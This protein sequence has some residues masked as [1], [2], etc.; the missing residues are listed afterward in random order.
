MT[1]IIANSRIDALREK[2]ASV[3]DEMTRQTTAPELPAPP[4]ALALSRR[5]LVD[6]RYKVLVV[7]EAK[8]GKST[9]VHA[10]I[11]RDLLPTDV[12]IATSQV[13]LVSKAAREGYRVR[14]EDGSA[15]EIRAEDL[16]KY[17]S[18][19]LADA[20]ETP[21]L[22]QIVRWI[23]ADVPA[24]FLPEGI[25]ILDTPGLGSLYAAHD[26]ITQRFIPQADAVIYT[27]DSTQPLGDYDLDALAAILEVTPH[28]FFIQTR[29]DQ[30]NR[31]AWQELQR[32]N[33]QI[34]R[35]RFSG[36][37]ADPRV[38]PISSVNLMKAAQTGDEDYEIVSRHRQLAAALRTFLFRATGWYRL[39]TAITIAADYRASARGTLAGRL[40]AESKLN[41]DENA[42]LRRTLAE[43]RR[44]FD[45]EW[46]ERGEGYRTLTK[47]LH[48]IAEL[49]R[50][51]FHQQLQPDGE[52]ERG[53]RERI[54]AATEM[55][56]AN[57]IGRT[58]GD[59]VS[60]QATRAWTKATSQ[61]QEH[62][63][64]LLEPFLMDIR[65]LDAPLRELAADSV[66]VAHHDDVFDH[67][68]SGL[69]AG[70]LFYSVAFTVVVV[71]FPP[72]A[73][74]VALGAALWGFLQGTGRVKQQQLD[75]AMQELRKHLS[76]VMGQTHQH[77]FRV[78]VASLRKGPA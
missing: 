36:R 14:M 46:G 11:G 41:M 39:A 27:L 9:F 6:N 26:R 23:E 57:E 16:P 53:I 3:I 62:V 69:L 28:V 63:A 15:L 20:G 64:H 73:P 49:G 1:K 67:L 40:A 37:L 76:K 52:I 13:F 31:T 44:L 2:A 54:D 51:G 77:F 60:R 4:A 24:R 38:W 58:M 33:E 65:E 43:R 42:A 50:Q 25:G 17:G 55:E 48:R 34:L 71:V 72:L 78:D 7:G 21:R 18:Q 68:K 70:S 22:D 66:E 12:D 19:V 32:R 56:T 8:R 29:I 47:E 74:A 35:E 61:T 59:E 10:L 45:R 30:V 5:K 75:K